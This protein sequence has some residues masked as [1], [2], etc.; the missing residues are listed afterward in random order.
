MVFGAGVVSFGEEGRESL[1]D[2]GRMMSHYADIV[3]IRYPNAG[4][5]DAFSKYATIPII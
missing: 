5:V 1:S 4:S 3:V 2:M